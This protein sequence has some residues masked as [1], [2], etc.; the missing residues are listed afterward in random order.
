MY[1]WK[2]LTKEKNTGE[3]FSPFALSHGKSSLIAKISVSLFAFLMGV[4]F[5]LIFVYSIFPSLLYNTTKSI[6]EDFAV[7]LY[8]KTISDSAPASKNADAEQVF[9]QPEEPKV[10]IPRD[11]FKDV[12]SENSDIV[13]RINLQPL[14]IKYLVTQSDDNEY[15]LGIGYDK[16]ENKSGTIFLDYRCDT[17]AQPLCGHYILYGH[18]MR[19]GS[20][21]HNLMEYKNELF[22]YENPVISFD[23]LY[24]DHKWEIFSAYVSDT[25]FYFI[26]TD[27]EDDRQWLAFLNSIKNKS[28][29]KTDIKLTAE[30]VVLTLCTCSYEFDDARFVVHA[31]L[32]K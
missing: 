6:K 20:M 22:F 14:G 2:W 29:H 25:N 13:G 19:N 32:V 24:E 11:C 26:D 27:F 28:M 30:D 23:T 9:E 5:I 18:N 4:G 21:F 17:K 10:L 1:K 12:L 3:H 31:K 7:S 15:Y 16:E 8:E